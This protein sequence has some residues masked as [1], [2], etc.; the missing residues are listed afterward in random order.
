MVLSPPPKTSAV[1][2]W[3]CLVGRGYGSH[4]A[5]SQVLSLLHEAVDGPCM[6]VWPWRAV[7][8]QPGGPLS[9]SE[10][11]CCRTHRTASISKPGPTHRMH[12]RAV[13]WHK[14]VVRGSSVFTAGPSMESGQLGLKRPEVPDGSQ[15]RGFKYKVREMV[16]GCVI[17][18]CTLSDCYW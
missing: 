3:S 18:L 8:L 2:L 5:P 16:P 14:V 10:N 6:R 13:L 4:V 12:S 9:A 7:S 17:S 1:S 15:G 11:N